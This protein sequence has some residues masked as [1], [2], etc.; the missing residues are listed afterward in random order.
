[1][2]TKPSQRFGTPT[3]ECP[4]GGDVRKYASTEERA[5]KSQKMTGRHFGFTEKVYGLPFST[6]PQRHGLELHVPIMYRYIVYYYYGSAY[7]C[8]G[9]VLTVILV[10]GLGLGLVLFYLS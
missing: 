6:T 7:I 1:M 10:L 9:I 4:R 5:T 2:S 8:L 3:L